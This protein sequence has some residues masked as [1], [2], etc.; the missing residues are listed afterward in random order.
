MRTTTMHFVI[1]LP[2]NNTG[3][4]SRT[5]SISL[6]FLSFSS[7]NPTPPLHLSLP[8]PLAQSGCGVLRACDPAC[9]RIHAWR[10]CERVLTDMH[11]S[12]SSSYGMHVSSSSYD[13]HVS[14][15]SLPSSTWWK[16]AGK[17]ALTELCILCYFLGHNHACHAKRRILAFHVSF[18]GIIIFSKETWFFFGEKPRVPG[19]LWP[20]DTLHTWFFS[21][22]FLSATCA[23]R[24]FSCY[25]L[26][27]KI[28]RYKYKY[29]YL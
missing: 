8:Y 20:I 21:A 25:H 27:L 15:S 9:V 2:G 10:V 18:W 1:T 24:H 7:P 12:S 6:F 23:A 26:N 13:M 4:G 17:I 29:T 19:I 14:S 11:V 22:C 5:R 28:I 16:H 3:N